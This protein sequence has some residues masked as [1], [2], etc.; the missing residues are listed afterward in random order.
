ISAEHEARIALRAARDDKPEVTRLLRC[1]A[2]KA[3]RIVVE[4]RREPALSFRHAPTLARRIVLDLIALDLADA[5]VMRFGVTEIEAA[6]RGARPHR[7][8][9]GQRH[10]DPLAVDQLEQRTLL[11]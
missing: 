6:D 11:G 5:E 10:T 3:Q 9:F 7:E 1:L 8:A 2:R 4:H